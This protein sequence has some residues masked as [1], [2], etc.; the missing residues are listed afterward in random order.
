MKLF[1]TLNIS[2]GSVRSIGGK[3]TFSA[4]LI[5]AVVFALTVVNGLF[6]IRPKIQ[7]SLA[8]TKQAEEL[9]NTAKDLDRKLK[10][11]QS[12]DKE[13]LKQKINET[14]KYLPA[15]K[16]APQIIASYERLSSNLSLKS[17]TLNPGSISTESAKDAKPVVEQ[18]DT[19]SL[20]VQLNLSG[21]FDNVKNFLTRA[22][23]STRILTVDTFNI[24]GSDAEAGDLSL[25]VKLSYYFKPYFAKVLK[26]TDSV[27]DLTEGE[28]K[29]LSGI[30]NY[31]YIS[32]PFIAS[33]SSRPNPFAKF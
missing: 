14:V 30:A 20:V 15:E 32:E 6:L 23:S 2:T 4:S 12:Y 19:E 29:I 11:L 22:I 18:K 10:K 33:A 24:S 3:G 28:K 5:F 7:D 25:T 21:S 1:K 13:D 26:D 9:D 8:L 31:E 16:D 17:I 27:V